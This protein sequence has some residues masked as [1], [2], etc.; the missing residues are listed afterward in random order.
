MKF[1][2]TSVGAVIAVT[3][4]ATIGSV[5]ARAAENSSFPGAFSANV[6]I[7]S[8]Y[9]FRGLSQT[10]DA[11]A[12]QGGFDYE[13]GLA[14]PVALYLGAWGSNA[15]GNEEAVLFTTSRSF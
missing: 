13:V 7:T 11:P 8:E 9:Y 4:T 10:D 14:K 3:I 1:G 15:N 2:L 5:A 6:A 12:L